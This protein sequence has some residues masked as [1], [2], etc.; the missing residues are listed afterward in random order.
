MTNSIINGPVNLIRLESKKTNKILYAFGDIHLSKQY[1]LKK[2]V[3]AL[4]FT[5]YFVRKM[6]KTKHKI[7]F[8]Y[9]ADLD[10]GIKRD[11]DIIFDKVSKNYID[12]IEIFLK[13]YFYFANSGNVYVNDK[14]PNLRLHFFDIRRILDNH[15]SVLMSNCDLNVASETKIK[16]LNNIEISEIEKKSII[17]ILKMS[18][19]NL[20]KNKLFKKIKF[21]KKV[22]KRTF[23]FRKFEIKKIYLIYK[24][25]TKFKNKKLKKIFLKKF[26]EYVLE[27]D[28]SLDLWN[29]ECKK[30]NELLYN[31]NKYTMYD[32]VDYN[33]GIYKN[34]I[35]YGHDSFIL[36]QDILNHLDCLSNYNEKIRHYLAF[37]TDLF[38][39]KRFMD[40]NY[41]ETA[42]SYTGF[43]HTIHCVYFLVKYFDFEITNFDYCKLSLDE[44]NEYI[45]S[46]V[47][48]QHDQY[49]KIDKIYELFNKPRL[50]QGIDL[51]NFSKIFK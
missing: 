16:S 35:G 1:E 26:D 3:T 32:V 24:F 12:E 31:I 8:F 33:N 27:L 6:E 19:A 51:K 36:D 15:S 17:H 29:E 2:D 23:E 28:K 40:K 21:F 20:K 30:L 4:S 39:L 50:E 7:D 5:Q 25:K 13:D 22:D 49:D 47:V 9:E 14:L 48:D 37:I 18:P 11:D 42:V 34:S 38:L 10:M 46:D 45:K 44:I 41:I 43:L